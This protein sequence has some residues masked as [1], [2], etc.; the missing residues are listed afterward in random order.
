[1]SAARSQVLQIEKDE[2]LPWTQRRERDPRVKLVGHSVHGLRKNDMKQ[3]ID[4]G[5][6]GSQKVS[7]QKRCQ[8]QMSA[9]FQ[10]LLIISRKASGIL[11]PL[12]E[13]RSTIRHPREPR[14]S[15]SPAPILG[16]FAT[17]F[18]VNSAFHC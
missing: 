6:R 9:S 14:S 4:H 16:Y 10:K 12:R 13:D 15:S 11:R 17:R 18:Y 8:R 2:E 3:G 1:M 7:R 5:L